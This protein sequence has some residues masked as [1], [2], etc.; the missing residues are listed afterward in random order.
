MAVLLV[1]D[2]E[3]ANGR[4]AVAILR[5]RSDIDLIVSDVQMPIMGGIELATAAEV[6]QPGIGIILFSG[7]FPP[8]SSMRWSFLRKPFG[9]K[10]LGTMIED[11]LETKEIAR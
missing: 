3:A 4:E 1:V 2:D 6:L 9:L 10:L 7:Y 11:M 5:Q 8:A